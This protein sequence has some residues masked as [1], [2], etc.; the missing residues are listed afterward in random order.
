MTYVF[1]VA[2]VGPVA[3]KVTGRPARGIRAVSYT[4]SRGITDGRNG[5][6]ALR[7][8]KPGVTPVPWSDVSGARGSW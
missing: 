7:P 1:S 6:H 4:A 3:R 2:G 5:E 8:A